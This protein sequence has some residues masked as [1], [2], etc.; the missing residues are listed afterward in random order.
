MAGD[1][2]ELYD[3]TLPVVYGYL[4][5][6]CRH[7]ETAEELTSETWLAAAAST[8]QPLTPAWILGV[9]RHKLL[10]HWRRQDRERRRLAELAA[11]LA[12]GRGAQDPWPDELDHLRAEAVLAAL[13]ADHRAALTFRYVDDLP[14]SEVARLVG[15]SEHGAE[16]LLARARR[17]FKAAYLENGTD[18]E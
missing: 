18:D 5:S 4:L 16:S 9:A 14:V 12:A 7:V 8:G 1:L 11:P 13:P 10:D 3:E 6:R 2:L 17:S 15:R